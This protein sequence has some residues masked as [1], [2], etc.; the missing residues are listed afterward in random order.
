MM[1]ELSSLDICIVLDCTGSMRKYI[2]A[3]RAQLY[4]LTASVKSTY[5]EFAIRF[6]FVGYRD[7]C[8][9]NRY[10]V[11]DFTTDV[12]ELEF[13]LCKQK[14]YG[15]GD[16]PEDVLGA[17]NICLDLNWSSNIRI[18]FHIGDA[19][20]HGYR[21]H[22]DRMHDDFPDGDPCGLTPEY[23][24]AG[25][26]KLN[27]Q[28]LFGRICKSTD[29][30]IDVFNNI[31]RAQGNEFGDF[32]QSVAMNDADEVA[33]SMT[34]AVTRTVSSSLSVSTS[35][36]T[37]A[38][39][40]CRAHS[41]TKLEY[42]T[43]RHQSV[44]D[45]QAKA[46]ADDPKRTRFPF[47]VEQSMSTNPMHVASD[48]S[49]NWDHVYKEKVVVYDMVP[50]DC[51]YDM[52]LTPSASLDASGRDINILADFG[53]ECEVKVPPTAFSQGAL[54]V[55][56]WCLLLFRNGI[57]S[58][59]T[60]SCP[61]SAAS[62]ASMFISPPISICEEQEQHEVG[63]FPLDDAAAAAVIMEE[64]ECMPDTTTTCCPPSSQFTASQT[65][66]LKYNLRDG[67]VMGGE[68]SRLACEDSVAVQ[69]V[70]VALCHIFNETKPTTFPSI[71]FDQQLKVLKVAYCPESMKEVFLDSDIQEY[72]VT[73][74][75][76][77][78]GEFEKL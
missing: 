28:Y 31:A 58:P 37:E 78:V 8:D 2:T 29:M 23:I 62:S 76:P 68:E 70:A 3:V 39:T 50:V 42:R 61:P 34:T 41:L 32:I 4:Q 60:G 66:V 52:L 26:R 54:R 73:L 11:L 5:P 7:H 36:S 14:A 77:L 48:A 24:F 9:D 25:L 21:F 45:V 18:L 64:R 15:G 71:L 17:L 38:S 12:N 44:V 72:W 33:E 55:A 65:L 75:P 63:N 46:R 35:V 10:F 27:L 19:P 20:C 57:L 53:V 51:I 22:P 69:R 47:K 56:F 74:E 43:F 49:I 40:P 67:R 13:A 6:A 16:R 1:Q 59:V 30:M